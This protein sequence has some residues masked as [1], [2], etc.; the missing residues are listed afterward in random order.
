MDKTWITIFLII[1][2]L[3]LVKMRIRKI[4][5]WKKC[6]HSTEAPDFPAEV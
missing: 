5:K 6:P 3:V 4:E 2:I 1:M